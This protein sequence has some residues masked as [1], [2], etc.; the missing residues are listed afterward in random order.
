MAN[1]ES[2]ALSRVLAINLDG[3]DEAIGRQLMAEG[4][5]P[6]LR[7][8]SQVSARFWLDHGPALRTGLAGEHVATG[9]SPKDARRWAAV[10]F[11]PATYAV[12]QEGTALAP[13]TDA[14]GPRAVVFDPTYF[15][16]ARAP[17]TRG[18]VAWGAHDPGVSTMS[19][20]PTLLK[21]V[22]ATFGAYPASEWL[23]GTPWNSLSASRQMGDQLSE[24]VRLRTRVARWLYGERLP[25]WELALLTVSEAH[26]ALEGL[27]HGIDPNHPL[28][29]CSSATAAAAGIRA[30]YA[31]IDNLIAELRAAFPDA[32][33]VVFSMHGMGPNRSDAGSM[34]LLAE[35]LYRRAFGSAHFDRSAEGAAALNGQMALTESESWDS[36]IAAGLPA[37]PPKREPL[38]LRIPRR[39]M[40]VT[41]KRIKRMLNRLT[42]RSG[43]GPTLPLTLD[44]MPAARYQ[45]F[46]HR[47]PVFALPSFYD[48]RVRINLRG[49]EANGIVD[50]AD[51]QRFRDDLVA[52][53]EQCQDPISGK[54]VVQGIEYP[55]TSDPLKMGPTES[56]LVIL[57]GG[58]PM[59]LVHTKHGQIGPIPYRRTGGHT[60]GPGFAF[61][62]SAGIE[63]GEFGSR[64]A[65]D[66]VPTIFELMGL[67]A[68]KDLSG[69]PLISIAGERHRRVKSA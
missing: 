65:H 25:D 26:S 4:K 58:A 12:R 59:G 47:M 68:R 8:L 54:G 29:A 33:L 31:A 7:E 37:E 32:A 51:Y 19:N 48:G 66:V 43:S 57:W 17:R 50:P 52:T 64:S 16:L 67:P 22:N 20:P 24:A 49:R 41:G 39:V 14:L 21:E 18:I 15:D 55:E 28:H 42:S 1:K 61:V 30:V 56:D 6:A 35:L 3:Y 36:W 63:P 2:L 13:F 27:W 9:L 45:R 69:A 10:S 34:L 11:D 44:W 62:H 38:W 46:W 40:P 53:L 23:Y 5:M 60:G